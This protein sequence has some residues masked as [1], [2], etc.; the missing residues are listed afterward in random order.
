M[1][2]RDADP[3]NAVDLKSY[4]E[5]LG[6]L[7]GEWHENDTDA[8][9]SILAEYLTSGR[10]AYDGAKA[11]RMIMERAERIIER[12]EETRQTGPEDVE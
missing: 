9:A 12:A 10:D 8:V 2:I 5:T 1:Y 4:K 6:Q 3:E 7:L 11:F